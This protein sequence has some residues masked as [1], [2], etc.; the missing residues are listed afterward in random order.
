MGGEN[1]N[2]EMKDRFVGRDGHLTERAVNRWLAGEFG[3]DDATFV[4]EHL[5]ECSRCNERVEAVRAF[6]RS[7]EIAPSAAVRAAARVGAAPVVSLD[8]RR[9]KQRV[10]AIILAVGMAAGIALVVSQSGPGPARVEPGVDDEVRFKGGGLALDV[11]AHD[12]QKTR[13]LHQGDV[14]HPGERLGFRVTSREGGW[15]L[16]LGVDEAGQVYPVHP[17]DGNAAFVDA[18]TDKHDLESAVRLDDVGSKERIVAARCPLRFALGE[19]GEVVKGATSLRTAPGED[20]W[21][22]CVYHET[23]LRKTLR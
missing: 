6:D 8:A 9:T 11:F 2:N 3:G 1:D 5:V 23:T 14:V 4:R 7:F 20:R 22:Q 19:I 13:P 17:P 10:A 16:V 15:L 12:G 18:G 21:A